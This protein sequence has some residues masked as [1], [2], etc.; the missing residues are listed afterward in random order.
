MRIPGIITWALAP[1]LLA[2]GGCAG[3][4]TTAD[5]GAAAAPSLA[6]APGYIPAGQMP[7][8]ARL[9]PPP[10][11]AGSAAQAFDEAIHDAAVKLRGTARWHMAERDASLRPEDTLT[12][13]S[14]TLG[15]DINPADTPK[16]ARLLQRSMRD[17]GMST[18]PAKSLY[19]RT[20]PFVAHNES[21]CAPEEEAVLRTNG[22]YPSGHAALGWGAA[23]VLA[24]VAPELADEIMLRGRSYGESRIICNYHWQTDVMAART[25]AAATVARM[26]AEPAFVRD[27][28]AARRELATVRA[29]GLPPKRDCAA[30]AQALSMKLPGAL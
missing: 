29:R 13:Y 19:N 6:S 11:A 14:C 25:A 18:G 5:A 21:T 26:H 2:V 16:L 3:T 30:Q 1:A 10:P 9:L 24:E 17:A 4:K 12:A 28:A 15:I 8:T 20:R 22:S 7:D 23:L 27:V